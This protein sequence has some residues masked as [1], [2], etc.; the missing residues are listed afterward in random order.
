MGSSSNL[1]LWASP[2]PKHVSALN[3]V[4]GLP[5]CK[6]EG[7]WELLRSACPHSNTRN[8]RE[9]PVNTEGKVNS[10]WVKNVSPSP[11]SKQPLNI[12][13]IVHCQVAADGISKHTIRGK[14]ICRRGKACFVSLAI[15]QQQ[16]LR[17]KEMSLQDHAFCAEG[18][19]PELSGTAEPRRLQRQSDRLRCSSI[20][21]RSCR[22]IPECLIYDL[23]N[24][25]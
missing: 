10:D 7:L 13:N 2:W 20:R 25:F 14:V 15:Y 5:G 19:K 12:D 11:L 8:E 17:W 3:C 23:I 21:Y 9:K 4:P 6:K 16:S 22:T 24:K 1:K 18:R